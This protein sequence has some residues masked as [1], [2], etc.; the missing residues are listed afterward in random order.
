MACSDPQLLALKNQSTDRPNT[1][2]AAPALNRQR[3]R[4]FGICA[5]LLFIAFG[6]PLLEFARF[7]LVKDRN[8]Y[9][10]LIPAIAGY[11]VSIKRPEL[12]RIFRPSIPQAVSAAV[13]GAVGVSLI[14]SIEDPVNRLSLEIFS[15]LALFLAVCF[16]FLGAAFL[17][18]IQ[19]PIAFLIFAVPMPT[20]LG[21][22]IEIFLQYASAEA[23]YWMLSI[24][25]T[26]MLRDG[27]DF[28]L[29][30]I[31]IHVAQE[32]SGYNSTFALFVVSTVAAH[33]FL[34]SPWKRVAL[35]AVV[36]P[37]AILRNGFRIT[38]IALLCV[39]VD[40][41]MIDSSIHHRGGPIF[42]ALSLLPFFALL[43]L[44]R[45]SEVIRTRSA[46]F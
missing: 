14:A 15:L 26:P 3:F 41:K 17:R 37:L 1:D 7:A 8:T 39:H 22:A 20:W 44:L 34:K 18:Q 28:L 21:N 36:V 24:A 46:T 10:L 2:D 35:V 40:P 27:L 19:F 25:Q 38:T 31:P 29:P 32:C 16:F 33:L 42:F 43:W 12:K 9:L 13:V 6:G 45:R 23:A 4:A 11:L 5:A 30:G